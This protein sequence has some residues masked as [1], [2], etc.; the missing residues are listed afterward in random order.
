MTPLAQQS[1]DAALDIEGEAEHL[2]QS[3]LPPLPDIDNVGILPRVIKGKL[4]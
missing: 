3:E 4:L 1:D 2:A